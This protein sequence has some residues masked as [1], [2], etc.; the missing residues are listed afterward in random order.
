MGLAGT[1]AGGGGPAYAATAHAALESSAL[2]NFPDNAV[3]NCMCHSTENLY[4]FSDTALARASDDFYP[5][6][7]ASS[8]AHITACA[9]N[10]V[11]LGPLVQPD[12]DMFHSKHAAGH[13][14]A[15]ARAVSGGPVYTSDQP[16]MHD[17][18]L[19]RSLAFA[20]GTVLRCSRPAR[21]TARCL[22]ADVRKDGKT[23]LVLQN[24]NVCTAVLAA[25]NVQGSWWDRGLR[26]FV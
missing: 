16:G 6:D 13:M 15:V 21:P 19:L 17:V 8:A 25:I 18:E 22:F 14:H 1:V 12:W 4:H 24:V 20:D 5:R 11:F 23:V 7:P 3:I 2:H 26:R 10:S 9:Y